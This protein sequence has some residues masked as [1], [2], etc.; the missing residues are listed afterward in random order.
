M[1]SRPGWVGR[2][3]DPAKPHRAAGPTVSAM[4]SG[5]GTSEQAA[6]GPGRGRVLWQPPA[7]VG[8][9]SRIGRYL[10]WL[11]AER[12]LSFADYDALWRWSVADLDAFWRSIWDHFQLDAATPVDT[13]LADA[14]MPG[15]RWF[16]GVELNYA[17]HALRSE[18]DG[19]ALVARSQSRGR[20]ELSMAELRDQ[21]GRCRAGL[22]RLGVGRGDRVAAYLPNIPETVVAFLAT[23]SLGAVWSSCAP[24]FG[25]RSVV[26]RLRQI[27]PVVLLAVDGYRYGAKAVDRTAEVAAIRAELPSL[28]A[29]VSVPYLVAGTGAA[30]HDGSVT[31]AELLADPAEPAFDAVPFD[32]PLYVLFSSGT[33]GLPKPIVHGHGGILVEHHKVLALHNDLGPGDRFFWFST[34]GWMMWNYLVSGLLVG[35]TTV[36]FDGDPGHPD[37]TGL[38]HMAGEEGVTFFGTSAPFLLACRK[39]GIVPATV[40]DL[41]ALRGVGSTGAPLPAEGFDWVYE[42]VG[43]DLLLS[44]VSG[45][46]DVC[47]AFVGGCPMV[48]VRSGEISCR[49]LGAK[50]EAYDEEGRSVVGEQGELVITAPMPSMP[51]GFWG[52]DDGSRYRAAYFA[53][54]PGVWTHG[55]WITLFPDGACTIT[56]RSD[57]TLNRGGVRM[58]TAELYTV[59][60]ALPEVSESLVVHLED[61]AGGPGRL[62][63]FV[64]P[65][66]G[67]ALDDDL[68]RRISVALRTEL[69]PR[70]VPDEIHE[71]PGVPRTLSGKKLEVPVKRILSGA[72]PDRAAS[73]G[74]LANPEVLDAYASFR[75]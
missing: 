49:Y 58:G 7:D 39:E 34:T 62:V 40:A 41:S 13:A 35:A 50:V 52:D 36:L 4:S 33:T 47:T 29:T 73:R 63:L 45:G 70:H 14:S 48:P 51:V 30:P 16:P 9:R 32:H 37:L 18:P 5:E 43:G 55:D 38:W 20:V 1:R 61:P 6:G 71:V 66:P 27:E 2:P 67:V 12:G 64:A 10:R 24:E 19:P 21:V 25:T 23:A 68:R 56:G 15:A 17:A 74:S 3:C 69:S 72:D 59:V 42:A 11:D 53:G 46:T 57:A 26:D 31:W 65:A 60:D 8:E 44:S 28:R 54:H 22:V 75:R